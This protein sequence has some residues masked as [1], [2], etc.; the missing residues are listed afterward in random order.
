MF[1]KSFMVHI[2][3]VYSFLSHSS[4][5]LIHSS[6]DGHLS[7]LVW[8]YYKLKRHKHPFASFCAV[9]VFTFLEEYLG[10]KFLGQMVRIH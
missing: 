8:E 4:E 10:M 7:S 2:P 9:P 1:L 3:V 5:W 6:V